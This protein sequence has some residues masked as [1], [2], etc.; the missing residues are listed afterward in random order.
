[1][2]TQNSQAIIEAFVKVM[3]AETN[4]K[5]ELIVLIAKEMNMEI[6]VDLDMEH[7]DLYLQWR[8]KKEYSDKHKDA[9]GK[10]QWNPSPPEVM[11]WFR[12][13]NDE[14]YDA[15]ELEMNPPKPK[16]EKQSD[17]DYEKLQADREAKQKA[18][19]EAKANLLAKLKVDIIDI[20]KKNPL[21]VYTLD[22]KN[23]KIVEE[24]IADD[25]LFS[26]L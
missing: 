4:S 13:Y 7:L 23:C 26:L 2:S 14:G 8:A 1:M 20:R 3:S 11:G 24:E 16:V 15:I 21:K 9:K 18:D 5:A 12:H 22:E 19:E 6:T 10:V 17:A 25:G